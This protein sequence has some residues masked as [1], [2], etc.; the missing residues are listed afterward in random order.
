[1]RQRVMLCGLSARSVVVEHVRVAADVDHDLVAVAIGVDLVEHVA[2]LDLDPADLDRA[3]PPSG[4][5]A[6]ARAVVR[7]PAEGIGGAGERGLEIEEHGQLPEDDVAIGDR[8]GVDHGRLR[9]PGIS[10]CG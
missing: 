8:E 7:L 5:H 6:D 3:L 10:C 1:M 2:G 4:M 9:R